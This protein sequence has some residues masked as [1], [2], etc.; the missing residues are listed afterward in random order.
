MAQIP[1]FGSSPIGAQGSLARSMMSGQPAIDQESPLSAGFDPSLVVPQRPPMPN[2]SP[3]SA[4]SPALKALVNQSQA[5]MGQLQQPVSSSQSNQ[6]TLPVEDASP[7][8]PGVQVQSSEAMKIIGA[9]EHY[10][11][12]I[13]KKEQA[14]LPK[15]EPTV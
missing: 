8:Q 4:M 2:G 10:L 14:F 6:V 1:S 11:K 3:M 9:M 15:Q 13:T 5:P 12:H 7:N